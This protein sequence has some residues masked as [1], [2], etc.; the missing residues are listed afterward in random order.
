MKID[1]KYLPSRKFV[2]SLS[3]VL[4]LLIIILTV[5]YVGNK[6]IET[7]VVS[8]EN[9]LIVQG[10]KDLKVI[11]TDKDGLTDWEEALWK[12]N[13]KNPDTDGDGT[14]DGEEITLGRNPLISNTAGSGKEPNDKIDPSI[15]ASN[16]KD[17]EEWNNLNETEKFSR[18]LFSDY[19][20]VQPADGTPLSTDQTN[21]LIANSIANLPDLQLGQKYVV[22]D[23]KTIDNPT[24]K[25]ISDYSFKIN[26]ILNKGVEDNA[27]K[28]ISIVNEYLTKNDPKIL[29]D[30]EK[31]IAFYRKTAEEVI[32][33]E[34][35]KEVVASQLILANSLYNL[36]SLAKN[37]EVMD[38]NPLISIVAMGKY[39]QVVQDFTQATDNISLYLSKNL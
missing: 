11:D 10:I 1:R 34:T 32:N 23:I 2:V 12:T 20:A 19:I 33:V 21:Q 37:L 5:R 6:K 39:G 27:F 3:V 16:Q 38:T 29:S 8:N 7:L 24:A 31:V 25:N 28:E 35:P 13:P 36:S 15:I 9:E 30:I 14:F 22:G 17:E 18:L 4:A 26:T